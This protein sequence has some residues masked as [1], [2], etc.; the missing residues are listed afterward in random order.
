VTVR[1]LLRVA[2]LVTVSVEDS[3]RPEA[4]LTP[5]DSRRPPVTVVT[6]LTMDTMLS[7]VPRLLS[8]KFTFDTRLETSSLLMLV[9][10][11]LGM[12]SP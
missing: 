8:E 9:M 11:T 4:T 5:P 10:V 12:P 6:A 7:A 2:P 3:V 1:V